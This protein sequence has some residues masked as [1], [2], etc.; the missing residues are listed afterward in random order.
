MD[1]RHLGQRMRMEL[2]AQRMPAGHASIE[3]GQAVLV[4]MVMADVCAKHLDQ[5]IMLS[6]NMASSAKTH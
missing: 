4:S 5:E 1:A 6:A 3:T 2:T